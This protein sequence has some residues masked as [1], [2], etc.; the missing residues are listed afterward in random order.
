MAENHQRRNGLGY[1]LAAWCMKE[2]ISLPFAQ[3]G[4]DDTFAES[5]SYPLTLEKFGMDPASIASAARNLVA[6][7]K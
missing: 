7:K 5:G 4:L 6:A 3:L 1:E 2:G